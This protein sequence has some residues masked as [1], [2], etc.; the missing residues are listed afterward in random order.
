MSEL[1]LTVLRLGLL[2]AL[3]AFVFAVVGVLR[4]DLYGTRVN[5]RVAAPARGPAPARPAPARG[6]GAKPARK[7]PTRLVVT[8]GP[9]S[10]TTLPL[11][12]AGT[13]IGRS[14]ECALVLDDDYASGRHAR[15]Y[16][17]ERGQWLVE[18][19]R[20]TNG[21]YL[22]ATRLTEPREVTAG[23]V[24]RIGQTTLELQR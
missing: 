8:A 13:L 20:S 17:D 21:T 18:D 7:G 22:G 14:P 15:I 19:L 24:L 10:G 12:A 23:S 2:V 6:R 5:K 3:W 4:G 9:L 11:R 16:Q 1:T